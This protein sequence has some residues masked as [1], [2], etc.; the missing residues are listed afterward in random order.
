VRDHIAELGIDPRAAALIQLLRTHFA[1][2]PR[3]LT[4]LE[5][6]RD[7]LKRRPAWPEA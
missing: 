1:N 2:R 3:I 6:V 5:H 7:L 4:E